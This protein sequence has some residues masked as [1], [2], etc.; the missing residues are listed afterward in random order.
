MLQD[1]KDQHQPTP[2]LWF[3]VLSWYQLSLHLCGQFGLNLLRIVLFYC[4]KVKW[5]HNWTHYLKQFGVWNRVIGETEWLGDGVGRN[6]A[7]P[8]RWDRPKDTLLRSS[9]GGER[10]PFLMLIHDRRSCWYKSMGIQRNSRFK[11]IV[12]VS[13]LNANC[14]LFTTFNL[15]VTNSGKGC[16]NLRD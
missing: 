3:K 8:T 11:D 13:P 6:K 16:G 12:T 5:F 2:W 1:A 15:Y 9:R 10:R 7:N 4:E 14:L